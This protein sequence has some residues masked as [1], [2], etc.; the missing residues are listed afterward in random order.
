MTARTASCACPLCGVFGATE[1]YREAA[2]DYWR[3]AN[4]ALV[5]LSPEQRLPFGE[6]IERYRLHRNSGHDSGYTNFLSRLAEP[7]IEHVR[8]GAV[9]LDYGCGPAAALAMLMTRSGRPTDFYD[10]VF[11][12]KPS[13]LAKRYDFVTCSEVLEH[14]HRPLSVLR[15]LERLVRQG[16][17]IGTMTGWYDRHTSFADWPYR[18]D[19]THVCFFSEHTMRWLAKKFGW[20][21]TIAATDVA[22]YTR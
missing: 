15:L 14:A 1:W 9:G 3:C 2:H 11:H 18:R 6:E 5:F 19:P 8:A 20:Q 10:P 13:L 17:K 16:G 21:L 7:M 12:P 4:C 22:I